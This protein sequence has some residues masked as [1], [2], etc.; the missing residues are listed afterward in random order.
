MLWYGHGREKIPSYIEFDSFRSIK[1]LPIMIKT[2]DIEKFDVIILCA[3]LSDYIPKKFNGKIPS[4][5]ENLLIDLKPAEKIISLLRK[6]AKNAK[7]IGFK[8]DEKKDILI[9]KAKNLLHKNNI[10][11]VV[12]NIIDGFEKDKNEI[13]IINKNEE[14]FHK[15]DK[16]DQLSNY[17]LDLII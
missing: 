12:A 11:F 6:K 13:W 8:V 16:K 10:D 9:K 2:N 14:I 3:A 17:I 15:K 7:I 1:D 4:G 5:K